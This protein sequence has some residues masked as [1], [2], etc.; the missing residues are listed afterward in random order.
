M[1]VQKMKPS[2][3]RTQKSL[4]RDLERRESLSTHRKQ[5]RMN[6]RYTALEKLI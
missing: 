5:G 1:E 2:F 4:S 6:V 3:K